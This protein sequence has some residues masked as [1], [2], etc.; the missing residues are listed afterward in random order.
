MIENTVEPYLYIHLRH[1]SSKKA[2][3]TPHDPCIHLRRVSPK[4]A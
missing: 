4:K 2:L 3:K 1:V